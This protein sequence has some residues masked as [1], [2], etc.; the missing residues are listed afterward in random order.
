VETLVVAAFLGATVI[1]FLGGI[2]FMFLRILV[3][4]P[5]EL[6]LMRHRLFL[7]LVAGL[8][9]LVAAG[10]PVI[11]HDNPKFFPWSFVLSAVMV[12]AAIRLVLGAKA[13]WAAWLAA[14][15]LLVIFGFA[16]LHGK[17]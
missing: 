1:L 13:R 11:A 7:S 14:S 4:A 5:H 3:N 12:L 10:F 17:Q 16:I 8:L 2:V 15:L 6:P 9:I